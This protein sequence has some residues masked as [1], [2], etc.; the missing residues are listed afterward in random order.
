MDIKNTIWKDVIKYINDEI[1]TNKYYLKNGYIDIFKKMYFFPKYKIER[2]IVIIK[3]QCSNQSLTVGVNRNND[4]FFDNGIMYNTMVQINSQ[5]INLNNDELDYIESLLLHELLHV[6]QNYNLNGNIPN[7]FKLASLNTIKISRFNSNHNLYLISSLLYLSCTHELSAQI[8][9][10]YDYKLKNKRYE[11]IF[12]II[13]LIQNFNINDIKIDDELVNGLNVI[14]KEYI[15]IID[16][17][18]GIWKKE[19]NTDNAIIFLKNI[20]KKIKKSLVFIKDKMKQIDDKIFTWEHIS[21]ST[22]ESFS[23]IYKKN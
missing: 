13:N 21:K 1:K 8:H 11:Y 14:R 12:Q 19:I 6:I 22:N 9:Q 18:Y 15:N 20:D 5:Y 7:H 16:D 10:Y 17:S 4:T 23:L 2:L 3:F